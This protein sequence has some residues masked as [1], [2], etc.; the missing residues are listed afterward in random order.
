MPVP[1]RKN[2]KSRSDKRHANKG[3]KVKNPAVCQTCNSPIASHK[4]CEECGYYKG[5]KVLRTKTDRMH[6]RGQARKA[7]EDAKKATAPSVEAPGVE[8]DK[9]D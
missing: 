5:V 6:D 1:K 8:E 3:L 9:K 2:S 7:Q 4:A